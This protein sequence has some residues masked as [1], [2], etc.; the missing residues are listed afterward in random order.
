M[1][2]SHMG[3]AILA[4][5]VMPPRASAG[6]LWSL[7]E[8]NRHDSSYQ[9]ANLEKALR[10]RQITSLLAAAAPTGQVPDTVESLVREASMVLE[11]HGDHVLLRSGPHE[12]DGLYAF[13]LGGQTSSLVLQAPHGWYDLDTGRL[14]AALFEGGTGAVACFNTAHRYLG[15]ERRATGA[16]VAHRPGSAFQAATIGLADGLADPMVVQV[17]GFS[18]QEYSYSAVIS[19]G[20]AFQ[21]ARWVESSVRLLNPLLGAHGPVVTSTMVPGLAATTNVQARVLAGHARFLH[22][23]LA[24]EARKSLVENPDQLRELGTILQDLAERRK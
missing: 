16:D 17:H 23:E 12:A 21:P 8:L 20:L 5:L 18:D 13:R 7:V 14:V 1:K 2:A 3:L 9:D 19:G 4:L 10:I 6:D 22:L 15:Q 24:P 11:Y